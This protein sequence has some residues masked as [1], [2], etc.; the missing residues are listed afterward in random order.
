MQIRRVDVVQG[1]RPVVGLDD[2]DRRSVLNQHSA[3]ALAN[4]AGVWRKVLQQQRCKPELGTVVAD[5][6]GC[7]L[8]T[9]D[10]ADE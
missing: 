1:L 7:L 4:V 2:L 3:Q 6:Q 8:Y 10:A 9:S 5:D